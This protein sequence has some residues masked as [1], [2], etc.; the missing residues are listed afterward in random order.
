MLVTLPNQENSTAQTVVLYTTTGV[1]AGQPGRDYWLDLLEPS[2]KPPHVTVTGSSGLSVSSEDG[3]LE[4][5]GR[6]GKQVRPAGQGPW[7]L[8]PPAPPSSTA[9]PLATGP[10]TAGWRDEDGGTT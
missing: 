7:T 9:P 3:R 4:G 10:H 6:S 1:C 8:H 2:T 5:R